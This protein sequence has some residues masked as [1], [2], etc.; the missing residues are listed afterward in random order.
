MS[1]SACGLGWYSTVARCWMEC[2]GDQSGCLCGGGSE[3]GGG[4]ADGQP[5]AVDEPDR[6]DLPVGKLT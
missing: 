4:F 1:G 3:P 2:V 6:G 5:V